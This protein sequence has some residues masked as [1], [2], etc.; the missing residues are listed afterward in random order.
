MRIS[1]P[2]HELKTIRSRQKSH[3]ATNH[4]H[5]IVAGEGSALAWNCDLSGFLRVHQIASCDCH[6]F[7]KTVQHGHHLMDGGRGG[8]GRSERQS[9]RGGKMG[10]QTNIL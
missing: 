2:L 10:G 3:F 9:P 7:T 8:C 4:E 1:H 6:A 5:D